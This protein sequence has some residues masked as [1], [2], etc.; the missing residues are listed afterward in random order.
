MAGVWTGAEDRQVHFQA[1]ALGQGA[2]MS[3]PTFGI[4]LRKVWNDGTLGVTPDD[5]F[6]VPST[7]VNGGC[8]G[9]EEDPVSE[10]VEKKE[11]YY[12]E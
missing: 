1:T 6:I 10:E 11:E 9:N 8:T 5:H 4:F 3:L 7:L 12:F 2:H